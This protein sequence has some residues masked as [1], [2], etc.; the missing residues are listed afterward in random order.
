MKIWAI[1]KENG[2]ER[3][4]GLEL[5]GVDR[6][7]AISELY[8]IARNLFPVNLICFGKRESR[9]RRPFKATLYACTQLRL[10][11]GRILLRNLG[12]PSRLNG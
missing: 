10:A 1:S 11:A 6:E 5:D 2:Y 7:T 3:E 8:K 12:I 4:I 9:A